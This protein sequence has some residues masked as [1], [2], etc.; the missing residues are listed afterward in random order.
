M[1]S[2][3]KKV[4]APAAF[5]PVPWEPADASALQA[6]AAG[7]ASPEQQKRALNWLVYQA[8]GTYDLDYRPDAREHAFVSGRRFVGLECIKLLK[9]HPG[10]FTK[11][12]EE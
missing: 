7:T 2:I 3:T 1:K 8:C 10:A 11:K 6:L 4:E 9:V 5:S 12:R